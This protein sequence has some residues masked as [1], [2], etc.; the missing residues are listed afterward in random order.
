[1]NIGAFIQ[2]V[3][4][5]ISSSLLYPAMTVLLLAFMGLIVSFGA[6]LAEWAERARIKAPADGDWPEILTGKKRPDHFMVGTLDKLD[7]ILSKKGKPG[8][9]DSNLWAEIDCLW[10]VVSRAHKRKLDFPRVLVRVGPSTGLIATLI[11]MS[12]GLAALS[13]GDMTR[14]SADLVVAFTATV[15][16]LAVGVTAF[17]LYSVRSRWLE[18]DL[19]TLELVMTSRAEEV[20]GS[21][22]GEKAQR[23]ESRKAAEFAAPEAK[24]KEDESPENAP[25][26]ALP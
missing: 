24:D 14:L 18:S 20:L 4:Y 15:V 23:D 21:P 3:L 22:G 10:R 7:A 9:T 25:K 6:F 26:T 19:E 1:M 8:V 17:A 12:T 16:G 13:Q 2:S 11:P 5:L